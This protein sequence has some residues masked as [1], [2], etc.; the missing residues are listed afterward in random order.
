MVI[1]VY[2]DKAVALCHLAGGSADE[3]DAAPG[4]ITHQIHTVLFYCL[5]H[6][7]DMCPQIIDA[8]GIMDGAVCFLFIER[9]Q[10][11]LHHHQGDLV[12]VVQLVQSVA[13][14]HRVDLPAPVAS[15][16]VRILDSTKQVAVG[17]QQVL[18]CGH[19]A[20]HVVGEGEEIHRAIAQGL[21]IAGLHFDLHIVLGPDALCKGRICTAHLH[22]TAVVVAVLPG[23]LVLDLILRVGRVGIVRS[24]GHH[25]AD[26]IFR[27]DA[28]AQ[29]HCLCAGHKLVMQGLIA[30]LRDIHLIVHVGGALVQDAQ[31]GVDAKGIHS[32]I[33]LVEGEP[34][35]HLALVAIENRL[36]VMQVIIDQAA[37]HPAIEVLGQ[38][39]RIFIVADGDKRFDPGSVQFIKHRIIKSQTLFIGLLLSA[40]GEDA[41]PADGHPVDLIAHLFHQGDIFLI[42]VIEITGLVVGVIQVIFQ[43]AGD[44][45]GRGVGAVG[46]VVSHTG[47]AA[48]LVPA[49]FKLV[50][51]GSAAPQKIC[52]KTHI[53]PIPFLSGKNQ[54]SSLNVTKV[55]A[56]VTT[57]A[58][59]TAMT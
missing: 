57:M 35:M 54:A 27:V 43:F 30:L 19:T 12:A 42:V 31:P 5:F 41:A 38:I 7:L 39:K 9:T 50:G 56:N 4:G 48:A 59:T 36:A 1:G 16:Q 2:I 46:H 49:A 52:R 29:L 15:F 26:L 14:T 18:I 10:T 22:V 24:D 51:C 53:L 21:G 40:G 33:D 13:Q 20:A 55:M 8:V 25:A 58:M 23:M 32:G 3:V 17:A 28:V 34:V 11:V 44:L 47:T 6:L 45:A 37:I